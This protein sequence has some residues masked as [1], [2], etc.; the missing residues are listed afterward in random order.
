MFFRHSYCLPLP[1][2]PLISPIKIEPTITVTIIIVHD[3]SP[4][5][6]EPKAV[7]MYCAVVFAVPPMLLPS[8]CVITVPTTT[9]TPNITKAIAA[10]ANTLNCP[11]FADS[12]KSTFKKFMFILVFLPLTAPLDYTGVSS[13]T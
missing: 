6:V 10:V 11:F 12:L 2:A 13:Q 1:K 8:V 4:P 7:A 3:A 5:P 9:T